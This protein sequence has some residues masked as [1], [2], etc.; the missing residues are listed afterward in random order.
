MPIQVPPFVQYQAPLIPLPARWASPPP[1]GNKFISCEV[2]WGTTVPLGQAVQVSL[3][4]GPVEFTQI[5]AFSVDNSRSGSDVSFLFPDTGRQLTVPSYNQGVY[6]V[7]TSALTFYVV[8]SNAAAGDVTVFEILNSE[9]PPVS[10]AASSQGTAHASPTVDL[11]AGGTTQVVPA[12]VN[13]TLT[14]FQISLSLSNTTASAQQCILTLVDGSTP[15]V[16]LWTTLVRIPAN[17]SQAYSITQ[18]NLRLRFTKGI[19]LTVGATTITANTSFATFN[20][21]YSVP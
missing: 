9:P 16:S 6:P 15:Q 4:S 12:T 14:G 13:G 1:E 19:S 17:T 11:G 3:N 10:V 7:F 2:D 18:S 20:L 8:A 21:F 5:V